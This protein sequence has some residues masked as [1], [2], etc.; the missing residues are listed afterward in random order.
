MAK[1]THEDVMALLKSVPG[2]SEHLEKP[3]VKMAREIA[4]R[5]IELGLTQT[6]LVELAKQRGIVLTQATVSKVEAGHEGVTQGT[7]D[8]VVMALG[9]LEDMQ[10]NFKEYPK[11]LVTV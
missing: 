5:R 9:G 1:F 3:S 6:K 7:I 11:S 2:V 4:K 10:V 8:K